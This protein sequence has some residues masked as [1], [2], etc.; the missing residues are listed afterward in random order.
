[1]PTAIFL[2]HPIPPGT[3]QL[4]PSWPPADWKAYVACYR[5]GFVFEYLKHDVHP[6]AV[7]TSAPVQPL[8]EDYFHFYL[9]PIECAEEDC[10]LSIE[11]HLCAE[12]GAAIDDVIAKIRLGNLA[13]ARCG[14]GHLANPQSA[15]SFQEEKGPIG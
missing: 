4:P 13:E 11:I 12:S 2:P 14:A 7:L 15:S 10:K 3:L 5:C 9:L 6:T 8:S 1:L